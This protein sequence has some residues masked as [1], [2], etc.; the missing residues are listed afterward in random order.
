[1]TPLDDAAR[2][3]TAFAHVLR[4]HGLSV[5]LENVTLFTQAIAAVGLASRDHVFWAGRTTLVHHVEDFDAYRAAFDQFWLGVA[6]T[7]ITAISVNQPQ[8]DDAT[9]TVG[10]Y[11]ATEVLRHK[12][13]A[14]YT[15][16]DYAHA[17]RLIANLR[18]APPGR[19]SRRHEPAT[20]G[21]PDLRRTVR[22]ALRNG[23]EAITVA[24]RRPGRRTRRLVLV[25]DISGSMEP[26][27]RA[28]LRFAHAATMAR[29]RVEVFALGTRL[30]RLTRQLKTYDP[31]LALTAAAGAVPDWS[32]GTRLGD[33]MRHFNDEWG[34]RGLARGAV[35]VLVS[36]GWD[37]GDP[38]ILGEQMARLH[39]VAHQV[40]WVNPLKASPGY[41]PLAGGMAAALPWVD[42]FV[43]GDSVA[44][45]ESL[46]LLLTAPSVPSSSFRRAGAGV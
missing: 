19:R 2:L 29:D 42:N 43:S 1:M 6:P 17:A 11:S 15:P 21:H 31:D 14:A 3:G 5:P 41:A 32:G 12:D 38:A 18:I 7:H 46:A 4:R 8:A 25:C 16:E 34:L 36:D 27:C 26:Y 33:G 40:V 23:G 39:R 37:R 45:L 20:G 30:T 24:R 28:L 22:R 35:V 44:A 10:R 13:F 9:Y